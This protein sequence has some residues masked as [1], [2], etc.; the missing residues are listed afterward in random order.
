MAQ[1]HAMGLDPSRYL[2]CSATTPLAPQVQQAMQGCQRHAWANPSSLHGFGLQAAEQLERQRQRL[3]ELL[4]CQSGRVVF[5]SGGTEAIHLAFLN[6]IISV[7]FL[8]VTA[9]LRQMNPESNYQ[10]GFIST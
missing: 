4:G 8:S 2:D 10:M 9:K 5:T 1:A 3:A 7:M 6:L